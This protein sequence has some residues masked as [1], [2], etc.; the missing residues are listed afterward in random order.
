MDQCI[1]CCCFSFCFSRTIVSSNNSSFFSYRFCWFF[2]LYFLAMIPFL[3]IVY[4]L[5]STV[6][7]RHVPTVNPVFLLRI[8]EC[9]LSLLPCVPLGSHLSLAFLHNSY[10]LRFYL[11]HPFISII[12]THLSLSCEQSSIADIRRI[13]LVHTS[14]ESRHCFRNMVPSYCN[15][16]TLRCNAECMADCSSNTLRICFLQVVTSAIHFRE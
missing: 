3:L 13:T 16:G 7:C 14:V 1:K 5:V 11:I 9:L 15:D 10:P 8:F 4:H 12:G 2:S 6:P